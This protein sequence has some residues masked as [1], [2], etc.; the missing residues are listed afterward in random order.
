MRKMRRNERNRKTKGLWCLGVVR[1]ERRDEIKKNRKTKGPC[2]CTP[3]VALDSPCRLTASSDPLIVWY[4]F[5]ISICCCLIWAFMSA[6]SLLAE[7]KVT[8][9]AR[10][11]RSICHMKEHV[12]SSSKSIHDQIMCKEHYIQSS[13]KSIHDHNPCEKQHTIPSDR[14]EPGDEHR[15]F[16]Q[17]A[18]TGAITP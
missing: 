3:R 18:L 14:C 15:S 5:L 1:C 8:S 17:K 9:A 4:C 12:Q 6:I 16:R 10:N 7:Q 13:R 2:T 11:D